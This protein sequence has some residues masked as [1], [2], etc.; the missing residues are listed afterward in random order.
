MAQDSTENRDAMSFPELIAWAWRE[1]PPVH[2]SA[3]NLLIHLIAVPLFV[4]GNLLVVPAIL[5]NHWLMLAA[6]LCVAVSLA[7]QKLGHSLEQVPVHPF[8]GARDFLRRLY[9]E[10][11]CNFW[12]FL[13]SG[14]WYASLMARDRSA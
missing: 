3:T 10:Q 2:K 5:F 9:A 4:I 14:Q 8:T 13:L 7:L 12:R 6:P 11:F 1:T